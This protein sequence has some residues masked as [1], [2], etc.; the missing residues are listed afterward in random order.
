MSIQQFFKPINEIPDLKGSLS[1]TMPSA[2]IASANQEVLKV[3]KPC[4]KKRGPYKE[5]VRL[6]V[7]M[8]S[9]VGWLS[10]TR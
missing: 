5:Y 1:A 8:Y 9:S 3:I 2:A 4:E 10:S 6:K 7:G